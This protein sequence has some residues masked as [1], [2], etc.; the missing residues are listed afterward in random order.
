MNN[1]KDM[2][3]KDNELL[4]S[5]VKF[6]HENSGLSFWQALRSWSR[7]NFIIGKMERF[8]EGVDTFYLEDKK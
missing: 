8:E 1:I 5:F 4:A 2:I 3:K 6:S 7:Y